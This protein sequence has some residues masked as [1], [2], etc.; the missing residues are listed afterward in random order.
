[1]GLVNSSLGGFNR[2]MQHNRLLERSNYCDP[3]FRSTKVRDVGRW[4]QGDSLR[5]IARLLERKPSS[6]FKQLRR[7]GG[8]QPVARSRS[9]RALPLDERELISRG[10]ASGQS[11]RAIARELNRAPSTISRR[12]LKTVVLFAIALLRLTKQ[13]G[14]V[15]YAQKNVN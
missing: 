14:T 12:L 10:L 13:L 8:M 6:V 7:T 11:L 2:S 4:R 9:S 5:E 3:I 15:P 1:M